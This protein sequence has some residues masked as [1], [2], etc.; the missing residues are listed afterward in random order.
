MPP[1]DPAGPG[2]STPMPSVTTSP[3]MLDQPL[4]DP[5]TEMKLTY[6]PGGAN[7]RWVSASTELPAVAGD[8]LHY[9]G[10]PEG[11]MAWGVHTQGADPP[12]FA[13]ARALHA[14]LGDRDGLAAIDNELGLLAEERGGSYRDVA[15]HR[16][17]QLVGPHATEADA[18][19]GARV[20]A[21]R[22]RAIAPR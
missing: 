5:E 9:L 6:G 17:E 21:F 10:T 2:E 7:Q 16:I 14:A 13:E 3:D 15:A 20:S 12:L 8:I 4:A 19:S 1:V 22:L 11:Q 18:P